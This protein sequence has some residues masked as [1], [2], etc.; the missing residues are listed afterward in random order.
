MSSA[1]MPESRCRW[2]IAAAASLFAL[3]SWANPDLDRCLL[4][5][6]RNAEP[7]ATVQTVRE[8]CE[9]HA[10][11]AGE[12]GEAAADDEFSGSLIRERIRRE[13]LAE[14]TRS[15]LIPHR[16][17]Y[18]IPVSYNRTPNDEP[19]RDLAGDLQIADEL[20]NFEA[21][22]QV[23][24]K[25]ALADGL[26]LDQDELMFGFTAKS[27]WQVYNK[28]ASAPFRETNYEPELFWAAPL[29]WRPFGAD[30]S[31]L[32]FGFTHQS[33]GR[34]GSLSR[35]WNRVYANFIL[36]RN[37][38]VFS[39]KPWW[40][41]PED[42]KDDPM[43]AE[44]DDNPDIEKFMGHFE[45]TT[46]YRRYDHEFGL[47]F[48]NNLRSDNKGAVQL[49]WT[50]PLWRNIRGYAQYFNGYGESLIDYDART[51]RVGI[52]FLLTDLL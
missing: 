1:A 45:F 20:D 41:I 15:I 39:L 37:R 2:L 23:S 18:L 9:Q 5:A 6:L 51:E 29:E 28:D 16:R 19:F 49:D 8:Q 44:G 32:L 36:E 24:L 21:T 48:R 10:E 47:M 34:G 17:N 31:F 25:F 35:S 40:R 38:F 22:F 3:P 7:T 33:N 26:L 52:G 11:A 27:F 13:Q 12:S 50:F 4:E 46:L 30:A 43:D 42:P 14:Q